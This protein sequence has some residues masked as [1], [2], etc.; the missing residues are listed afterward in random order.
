MGSWSIGFDWT[1]W[2]QGPMA[3]ICKHDDGRPASMT[4]WKS[5]LNVGRQGHVKLR[6]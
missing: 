6:L 3:G 4:S 1:V 2:E 5:N